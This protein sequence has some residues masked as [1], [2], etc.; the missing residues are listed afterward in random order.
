M[1]QILC[2]AGGKLALPTNV[3]T[4]RCIPASIDFLK[5]AEPVITPGTLRLI[6]KHT[7]EYIVN[8]KR[9]SNIRSIT[10]T[11]IYRV[12]TKQK[13]SSSSFCYFDDDQGLE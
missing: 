8:Q 11:H 3:Q 9:T 6:D 13:S 7:S 1:S 5:P 2:A 4:H 10:P 12:Y